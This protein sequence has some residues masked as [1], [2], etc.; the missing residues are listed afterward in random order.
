[1]SDDLPYAVSTSTIRIFGV[2]LLV[3]HLNTG[4]R[5]IDAKSVEELFEVMSSDQTPDIGDMDAIRELLA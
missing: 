2:D 5:V 4:Q 3:H 1:M